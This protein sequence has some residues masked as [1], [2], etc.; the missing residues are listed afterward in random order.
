MASDG[1]AVLFQLDIFRG[2]FAVRGFRVDGPL[3]GNIGR[4]LL[5]GRFLTVRHKDKT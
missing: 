1:V 2:R 4:R 3:P 5:W